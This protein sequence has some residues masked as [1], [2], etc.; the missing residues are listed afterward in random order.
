MNKRFQLGLI[1]II[2]A[3]SILGYFLIHNKKIENPVVK[4]YKN[5][6]LIKSIDLSKVKD[7][8]ELKIGDKIHYNLISVSRN[9]VKVIDSTCHDKVCMK[10]GKIH[11][12]LLPIACLPNNLLIKIEGERHDEFDTRT[13]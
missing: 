8:Y 2:L 7:S 3:I 11:D 13:Y 1:F 4:I 9:G 5:G 6:E 10:T 12:S